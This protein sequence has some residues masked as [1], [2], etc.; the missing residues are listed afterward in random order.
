LLKFLAE[1]FVFGALLLNSLAANKTRLM[2]AVIG[3]NNKVDT[4]VY[5]NDIA[6]VR[7]Q[8]FGNISGNWDMQK[9]LAMLFHKFGGAKGV[10]IVVKVFF[11]ALRIIWQLHTTAKCIYREQ[12]LRKRIVSI[13]H[14]VVLRLRKIWLNPFMLVF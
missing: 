6:N 5:A 2:L 1:L 11:H 14:K 8:G 7:V 12:V 13:P 4:P 10:D 9:I 3:C